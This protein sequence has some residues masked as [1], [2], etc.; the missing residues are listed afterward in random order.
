MTQQHTRI[1]K[2]I[3]QLEITILDQN[4]DDKNRDQLILLIRVS[5]SRSQRM[6]TVELIDNYILSFVLISAMKKL[7]S[8]IL[9]G[10]YLS[11]NDRV[12]KYIYEDFKNTRTTRNNSSD[13]MGKFSCYLVTRM[14]TDSVNR[15]EMQSKV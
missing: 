12:Y 9:I 10:P 3:A 15:L 7:S 4:F 6:R 11:N 1:T 2:Q 13:I 8:N 14:G 5:Q